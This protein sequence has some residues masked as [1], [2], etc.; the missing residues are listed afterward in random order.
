MIWGVTFAIGMLRIRVVVVRKSSAGHVVS[1][2][3]QAFSFHWRSRSMNKSRHGSMRRSRS[4]HGSMNRS[5][6]RHGSMNRSRSRHGSMNRSRSRHGSRHESR[7]RSRNRSRQGSRHRVR[8]S[9]VLSSHH[10]ISLCR[11]ELASIISRCL[12]VLFERISEELQWAFPTPLPLQNK[13][14]QL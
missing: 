5:R 3:I 2:I 9:R 1:S 14:C 4:R 7:N 11:L 6:S 13:T 8:N 10:Y 12:A